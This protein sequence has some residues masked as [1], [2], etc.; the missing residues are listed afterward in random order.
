MYVRKEQLTNS[1]QSVVH[2]FLSPY[3]DSIGYKLQPAGPG[4]ESTWA[5]TAIIPYIESLTPEGTLEAGYKAIADHDVELA[6]I[7]L[8]YLTADEQ[9]DRGVRV[10]GSETASDDRMPTISFVVTAGKNGEPA[11]KSKAVIDEFDK[12][13]KVSTQQK[14]LVIVMRKLSLIKDWDSL[15][16]FL[17]LLSN[18][19]S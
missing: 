7:I 1:V 15:R 17:C 18:S 4:Y 12:D 3:V 6:A 10:V 11:L 5:T 14:L 8:K 2:S 16:S 19:G 9:R 13:G